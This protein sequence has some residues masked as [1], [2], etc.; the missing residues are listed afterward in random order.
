[1]AWLLP[2]AT[3]WWRRGPRLDPGRYALARLLDDAAYCLG[4]WAGCARERALD[5]LIPRSRLRPRPH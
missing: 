2:S 1:V 4:V 5:P 3:E